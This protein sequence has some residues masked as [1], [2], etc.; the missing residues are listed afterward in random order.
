MT[1]TPATCD[2]CWDLASLVKAMRDAQKNYFELR[3][4]DRLKKS[5]ALEAKVDRMIAE[6][7]ATE[8]QGRLLGS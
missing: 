5:K 6:M 2:R 8:V 4:Q 7:T 3:G 1:T